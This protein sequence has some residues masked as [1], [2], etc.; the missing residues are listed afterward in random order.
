MRYKIEYFEPDLAQITNS[1]QKGIFFWEN[2][3]ILVFLNFVFSHANF[4]KIDIQL[5]RANLW[6][7]TS[8][9]HQLSATKLTIIWLKG[10]IGWLKL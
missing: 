4:G 3:L 7:S 5:P 6:F 8:M 9:K 1:S 2:W 10:K